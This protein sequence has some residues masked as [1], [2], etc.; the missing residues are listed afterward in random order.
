MS[1]YTRE[2]LVMHLRRRADKLELACTYHWSVADLRAAADMLERDALEL[3]ARQAKARGASDRAEVREYAD[4]ALATMQRLGMQVPS[5][6]RQARTLADNLDA[7]TG[8]A[9]PPEGS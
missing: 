9:E 3:E 8:S 4:S 5:A 7:L 1:D 6:A 2:E